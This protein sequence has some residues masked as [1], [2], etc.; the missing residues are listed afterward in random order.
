V[1][2]GIGTH[3]LSAFDLH[4]YESGIGGSGAAG[5]EGVGD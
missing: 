2:E 5:C 4:E 1:S 3:D